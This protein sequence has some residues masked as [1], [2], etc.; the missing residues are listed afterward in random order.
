MITKAFGDITVTNVVELEGPM[1]DPA[2][3]LPDFSLDALKPHEDWLV[4][5]HYDAEQNLLVSP[6][7]SFLVKTRHH[8]ILIDGC[9]GNDK[10]RANPKFSNL[11]QPWLE[12]LAAA[13]ATPEDIDFVMC[14]HLHGDH[15]GWNTRLENGHWVPTFP[16]AKYLFSQ[17]EWEHWRD[18]AD[19]DDPML[20]HLVDSVLPV[21]AAGQHELVQDDHEIE[22]GI[23]LDMLA[24]HTPG[25]MGFHI[26][27]GGSE[28]VLTGDMI[29]HPLQ[30]VYP[31]WSSGFCTDP[32]QA[33]QT[34]RGFLE[35]YADTGVTVVPS[36][37]PDPIWGF[38][39][40]AGD[41]F[42]WRYDE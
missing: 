40:S 5:R 3:L 32:E 16:N 24:G 39:D 34:R 37:F 19:E 15:V 21:V 29:H 13:G 17:A 2:R 33:R 35:T 11:N 18:K 14:T 26:R 42:K 20:R 41:G 4:P 23:T 28:A 7:Q 31:E 22:D 36:H 38:I 1:F 30:I 8:T 6:I 25:H 9:F 10:E 27:A 12:R